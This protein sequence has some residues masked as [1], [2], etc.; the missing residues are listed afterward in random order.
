MLI[1]DTVG[2]MAVILLCILHVSFC[3]FSSITALILICVKLI[4]SSYLFNSPF[5][6]LLLSPYFLR[7][8]PGDYN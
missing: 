1:I 5:S 7:G 4:Y 8:C 6:L 3:C 2:Y